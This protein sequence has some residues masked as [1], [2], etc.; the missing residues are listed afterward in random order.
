MSEYKIR[1]IPEDK[2]QAFMKKA[3]GGQMACTHLASLSLDGISG[4]FFIKLFKNSE[5]FG[6][7]NEITGYLLAHASGVPVPEHACLVKVPDL[8]MN[9]LGLN[10]NDYNNGVAFAI[11][12]VLGKTPASYWN[13]NMIPQC[14]S[15]MS[16]IASWDKVHDV[17]CFDDWVANLDRNIGNIVVENG[18]KISV[19]D[20]SNMPYDLVWD[21]K[22]LNYEDNLM[23]QNKLLN[24]I[25]YFKQ[26]DSG[27]P[28]P[29]AVS[30]CTA[31]DKHY[32]AF[33]SVE[34]ELNHWWSALLPLGH[35]DSLNSFFKERANHGSKRIALDLGLLVGF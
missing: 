10:P 35:N 27:I 21:K 2:Y 20:H 28:L 13:L 9:E 23:E 5:S 7:S 17:I 8:V 30:I 25:K 6:I 11:S 33:L 14:T 26:Y 4:E 18:N 29:E 15:L 32:S 31:N 12:K 1:V 24:A 16:L 22:L 34:S 3:E 19:I